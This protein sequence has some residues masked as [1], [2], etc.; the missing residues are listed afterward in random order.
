MKL[1]EQPL[2]ERQ[3]GRQ[4]PVPSV[5]PRETTGHGLRDRLRA[6]GVFALGCTLG[7]A[8]FAVYFLLYV[9]AVLAVALLPFL[10]PL[11]L[12]PVVLV[13]ALLIVAA[14]KVLPALGLLK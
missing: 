2:L 1:L 10:L 5:P 3:R 14:G 13:V 11:F 6:A 7:V 9:A 4:A 12:L 8:S